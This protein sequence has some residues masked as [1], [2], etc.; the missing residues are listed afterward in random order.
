VAPS[1]RAAAA[2]LS[3]FPG[4]GVQRDAGSVPW[5][6][7]CCQTQPPRRPPQVQPRDGG[8]SRAPPGSLP[9]RRVFERRFHGW[10]AAAGRHFSVWGLAGLG[11]CHLLLHAKQLRNLLI[12]ITE[13]YSAKIPALKHKCK[14][15]A[16]QRRKRTATQLPRSAPA[17]APRRA[18]VPATSGVT[19]SRPCPCHRPSP[20]PAGSDR[21]LRREAGGVLPAHPSREQF[22]PAE[23]PAPRHDWRMRATPAV[24]LPWSWS[25][26]TPKRGDAMPSA[27]T[28]SHGRARRGLTLPAAIRRRVSALQALDRVHLKLLL[29][30]WSTIYERAGNPR[31]ELFTPERPFRENSA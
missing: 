22:H 23:A 28:A 3:A 17:A 4:S 15:Y 24:S 2:R 29:L 1:P 6:G 16:N 31:C 18:P 11:L 13:F 26:P 12:L 9:L 10:A 14:S 8:R 20:C 5:A 7:G 25:S 19:S 30:V 21:E 27:S